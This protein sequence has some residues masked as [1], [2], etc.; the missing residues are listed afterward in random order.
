MHIYMDS[1]HN[2]YLLSLSEQCL[3][4]QVIIIVPHDSFN[5]GTI[6]VGGIY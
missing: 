6:K 1:Y 2:D 3:Y 5:V 4:C